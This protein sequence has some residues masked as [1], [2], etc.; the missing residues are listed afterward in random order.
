M[1][2]R[3]NDLKTNCKRL[4]EKGTFLTNQ[5]H[6][7]NDQKYLNGVLEG[8]I[9]SYYREFICFCT[10]LCDFSLFLMSPNQKK[11]ALFLSTSELIKRKTLTRLKP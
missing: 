9:A 4:N 11:P 7:D 5:V 10:E 2:G 6:W 3:R 8:Q 1:R